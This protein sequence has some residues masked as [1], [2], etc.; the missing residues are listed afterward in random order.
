[1]ATRKTLPIAMFQRLDN[2][3]LVAEASQVGFRVGERPPTHLDIEVKP[4][5]VQV[6]DYRGADTDFDGDIEVWKY[7]TPSK[8]N[9][10]KLIIFND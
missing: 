9:E 6:Y 3:T 8:T 4:N 2:G 5:M 10:Q 1:M 7:S